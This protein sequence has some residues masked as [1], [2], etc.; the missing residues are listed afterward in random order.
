M[1]SPAAPPARIPDSHK[2]AFWIYGVTAMVMREPLSVFIKDLSATGPASP[3]VQLEFL[4]VLVVFL[5]LSRQFLAAGVFFDR[6]YLQP[7]SAALFPRRSYPLDF[8][9]RMIELLVAVGASTAVGIHTRH[10]GGLSP[11]TILTAL[12]L[13]LQPV[14]LVL[15]WIA[16]Y[17]SAP[18]I[19]PAARA[20]AL[21]F[22]LADAIYMTMY[23][24]N[25]G[26]AKA[27]AA[28][29][30]SVVIVISLRLAAQVQSYGLAPGGQA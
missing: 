27:D 8:I 24:I 23:A 18:E 19:A 20:N 5:F 17:S 16:N 13:L 21:T 28:A 2:S 4:R 25:A 12:L 10:V 30:L 6:V 1:S 22:L 3:A 14:W 7:D 9:T 26:P 15:A 11:F 29:L